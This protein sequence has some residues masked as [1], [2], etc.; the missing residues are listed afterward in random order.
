MC[1]YATETEQPPPYAGPYQ[2]Y[3]PGLLPIL[4]IILVAIHF[5]VILVH[6]IVLLQQPHTDQFQHYRILGLYPHCSCMAFNNLVL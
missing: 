4:N 6:D 5:V 1:V 3:P 2:T